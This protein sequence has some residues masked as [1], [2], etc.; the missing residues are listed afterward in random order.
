MDPITENQD[1]NFKTL[2]T[3]RTGFLTIGSF[4]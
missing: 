3:L 4:Y 2:T 1:G